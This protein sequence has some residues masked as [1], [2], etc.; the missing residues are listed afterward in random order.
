MVR[1]RS[2]ERGTKI[3]KQIERKKDKDI[4]KWRK[5]WQREKIKK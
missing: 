1:L 4:Y 2:I 5:T 3:K